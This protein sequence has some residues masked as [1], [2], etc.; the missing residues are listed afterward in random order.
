M[1]YVIYKTTNLLTGQFYVGKW[2]T[3]N[4]ESRDYLG[5]GPALR[6]A[7]RKHGRPAFRRETMFVFDD[8]A[9]AKKKERELVT[10]KFCARTDTYNVGV[11]GRGSFAHI[12]HGETRNQWIGSVEHLDQL[13]RTRALTQSRRSRSISR[14]W[15]TDVEAKDRLRQGIAKSKAERGHWGPVTQTNV[16]RRRISIAMKTQ[17][18]A[19]RHPCLGT[20][21]MSKDGKTVKVPKRDIEQ[22]VNAGWKF[23]RR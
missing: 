8:A 16:A 1:V 2:G 18:R 22:R 11:G 15:A 9:A 20:R 4:P 3:N 19:G 12:N 17:A 6:A 21:W 10:E 5:S 13:R 23:G 14:R 7:I